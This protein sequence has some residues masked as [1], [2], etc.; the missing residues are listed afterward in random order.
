MEGSINN[1]KALLS[2]KEIKEK[3]ISMLPALAKLPEVQDEDISIK[4]GRKSSQ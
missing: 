2:G 1:T 4:T 3:K